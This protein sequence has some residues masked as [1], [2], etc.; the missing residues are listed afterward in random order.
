MSSEVAAETTSAPAVQN[1]AE[2]S[3]ESRTWGVVGHLS[4][5]IA[6]VGI[7]SLI[8]PLVVMLVQRD[9]DYAT[10]QAR[11]ALNFNL[12]FTIYAIVAGFSIL[13]LVG[14]LLLPAV[15]VTWFVLV[16]VASMEASNGREYRYPLTMRFID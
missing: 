3:S 5:F 6:F 7:P 1:R 2:R 14:I 9:D 15:M 12:S 16:I 8:G 4:A 13:L 11:E 10:R